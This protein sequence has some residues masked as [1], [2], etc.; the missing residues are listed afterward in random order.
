MLDDILKAIR[1]M[2][3]LRREPIYDGVVVHSVQ[4]FIFAIEAKT[5]RLPVSAPVGSATFAGL[6]VTENPLMPRGKAGLTL[7]GEIVAIVGIEET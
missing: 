6:Q 2:K 7:R 5:G 4:D 1:G 3:A